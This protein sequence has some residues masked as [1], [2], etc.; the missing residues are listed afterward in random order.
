MDSKEK[1]IEWLV[2]RMEEYRSL[3]NGIGSAIEDLD[4]L[5]KLGQGFVSVDALEEIDIGSGSDKRPT[6]M[7]AMLDEEQK[8]IVCEL[9]K[10]FIDYFA[11]EYIE[12]P[13]LDRGLVEHR[14]PIK[15][16]FCPYRQPACSFNSEVMV[17]VRGNREATESRFYSTMPLC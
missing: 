7:N 14:L 15:Q 2:R 4:G 6:F 1:N 12:M 13:G 3:E 9:F 10:G 11:W 16:G 17:K 8:R 5:G